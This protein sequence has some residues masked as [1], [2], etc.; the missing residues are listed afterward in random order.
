LSPKPPPATRIEALAG[1]HLR[2]AVLGR[3]A[4]IGE[5]A[6]R[7]AR[8]VAVLG[9]GCDLRQASELAELP[10]AV[11]VAAV[12]GLVAAGIFTR[13]RLAFAHPVV[14]TAVHE[15]LPSPI[16]AAAHGRAAAQLQAAGA[17]VEIVAAQLLAAEP[18]GAAWAESALATA[19][20]DALARGAP[21]SAVVFLRRALAERPAG[22]ESGELL[23]ALGNA[24]VR[25][26]DPAASDV[27]QQALETTRDPAARVQIAEAGFDPLTTNGRVAE[28]RSLLRAVLAETDDPGA[29]TRL[30]ARLA[31]SRA[32][33]GGAEDDNAIA[34]LRARSLNPGVAADRYAAGALALAGAVLDGGVA[35]EVLELARLAIGEE[36]AHL[37]D[38][39][40]GRPLYMALVALAVAGEPRPALQRSKRVIALSRARGS[41]MGQGLGLSWRA[42]LDVVA[43]NVMDAEND[44]RAALAVFADTGLRAIEPAP[45][46]AIAWALTER[47]ATD[48]A[49]ALLASV[50]DAQGWLGIGLRCARARLLIATH[51]YAEAL[52]ALAP[53]SEPGAGGWRSSAALPWRSLA[54][55]AH[56]GAGDGERARRLAHDEV[57]A[58]RRFGCSLDLGRALRVRGLAEGAP[59]GL[60]SLDAA[61]V[62]LRAGGV[63]LELAHALVDQGAMLRRGRRR[64]D[65]RAP[66]REGMEI[67]HRCGAT[68]LVAQARDELRAA[69]ARP[70]GVMRSGVEALT[71]SEH[72]VATLAGQRLTNVEIAQALFVTTRTV[73]T[74]LSGAYRKLGIT[75]R[76]ALPDALR[77]G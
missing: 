71:P 76:T 5:P 43:G 53:V 64:A 68:A 61:I 50:G 67:A 56:L 52:I 1:E 31:L 18:A 66:L 2:G 15:D 23:R 21:E 49:S 26:G 57:A 69:G 13:E 63:T 17:D 30:T 39:R 7:L 37:A 70:R 4:R 55:T 75:S 51:R 41:L 38:A 58:A 16:R 74:H 25:L 28:A 34:A 14:R 65:A 33:N 20:Q 48:E 6:A 12:D 24:M 59:G 72:R 46:L 60:A 19:A 27:L 3:L 47:G 45:S 54:V 29:V 9:D 22:P 62:A 8:A 40:A 10:P 77:T 35:E 32:L 44:G 36:A 42:L 11:A 73:E